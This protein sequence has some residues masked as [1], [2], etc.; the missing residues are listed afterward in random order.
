MKEK[1]GKQKQFKHSLFPGKMFIYF[2]AV[3]EVLYNT[4]R[5]IGAD[6]TELL[7]KFIGGNMATLPDTQTFEQQLPWPTSITLDHIY[8]TLKNGFVS[9]VPKTPIFGRL[10]FTFGT[11][12]WH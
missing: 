10:T 2:H 5:D 1:P 9:L 11:G 4:A 8:I 12:I 7:M 6:Y 3:M